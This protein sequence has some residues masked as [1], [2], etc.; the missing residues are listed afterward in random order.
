[1]TR[2]SLVPEGAVCWLDL[3]TS[4]VEGSRNFYCELFDWS[5]EEPRAEFGCYWMFMRGGLP[6]AGGMGEMGELRANNSWKIY[7]ASPD[8]SALVAVGEARGATF[9]APPMPVADLGVQA[10][11]EDPFGAALGLGSR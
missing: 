8:V 9:F 1:M 3:W 11:F 10:A 2:R 5:V 4:D 6:V 7:L